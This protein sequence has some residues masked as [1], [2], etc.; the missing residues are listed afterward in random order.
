MFT[1]RVARAIVVVLCAV[2]LLLPV[3][4]A[5]AQTIVTDPTHV[6]WNELLPPIPADYQGSL[7]HL[8]PGG[9]PRCVDVVI[10]EMTRRYNQLASRCDHDAVFALTYLR[11]TEE[12]RRAIQDPNFFVEPNFV[13]H[14]DVVFADYYFRA[15]DAH[16]AGRTNEVPAAWEIAFDAADA[17]QV[18]GG[19]NLLLGMSA[20]INR[21]LPFALA[22]IGIVRPDGTSRKE[23][24][25]RVDHFLINVTQTVVDEVARRFD[26]TADDTGVPGAGI[27]ETALFQMVVAWREQAWR[28]AELL[29]T[30][31]TPEV[32]ALVASQI[33]LTSAT[34]ART[35][36]TTYAY[37]PLLQNS[38]SRD[39]YCATHWNVP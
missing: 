37:V 2:A 22:E 28:N 9:Q 20:H 1:G 26:P 4:P 8:C 19:G 25:D 39:Q 34:I 32:R 16:H 27:D 15:F 6:P 7:S 30:A 35:L 13:N 29:V 18:R 5:N 24:H 38:R 23:D 12:Y 33:E 14:E 17:R 21:D 31:P 3:A 11:T 10:R 36:A